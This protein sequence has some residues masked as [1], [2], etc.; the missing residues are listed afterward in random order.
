MSV[1]LIANDVKVVNSMVRWELVSFC[2]E[3]WP[4]FRMTRPCENLF[5]RP[6]LPPLL[7]SGV[8]VLDAGLDDV[9]MMSR[10]DERRGEYVFL[11][12]QSAILTGQWL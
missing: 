2:S 9:A 12:T 11:R 7:D 4:G 1:I 10:A 6:C 8:A 5:A 3:S